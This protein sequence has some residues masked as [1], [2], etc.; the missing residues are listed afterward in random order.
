MQQRINTLIMLEEEREKAKSKFLA[1]QQ[2]VKRW[3]DKHK[4][5]EKNFE[6]GDLVLKWVRE[7]EPKGKHSMFQNLWLG[8]FQ[9]VEKIGAGTC[10]LQN[11][12]GEPD[13]FPV[14]GK[15]LKQYFQ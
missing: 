1:H 15:A 10:R 5:K 4:D 8:P 2:V 14:N 3:F 6:V 12:K 9:V 11:L 13:A 7:N